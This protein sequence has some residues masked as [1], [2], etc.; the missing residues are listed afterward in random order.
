MDYN[1]YKYIKGVGKVVT[2]AKISNIDIDKI[3]EEI[4]NGIKTKDMAINLN[5]SVKELKQHIKDNGYIW[6]GS[7]YIKEEAKAIEEKIKVTYRINKELQR[8]VKLQSIIE[9]TDNSTIIEKAIDKYISAE[10]KE[11]LK[12]L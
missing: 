7:K 11:T 12:R 8:L 3:V 10:T 6:R 9:D 1:V 5:V 2:E 4:N